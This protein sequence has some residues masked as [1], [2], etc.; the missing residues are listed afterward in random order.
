MPTYLVALVV[1]DLDHISRTERG[2][3][4]SREDPADKGQDAG[5]MLFA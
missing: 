5:C 4:V 1:C 3:E 2:K